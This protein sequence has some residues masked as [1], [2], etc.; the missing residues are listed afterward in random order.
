MAKHEDGRLSRGMGGGVAK[1]ED[2]R[3]SKGEWV[4]KL[5]ARLHDL[6]VRIQISLKNH[7]WVT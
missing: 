4:A 3:L 1:H 5:V 6:W 7:K 2:G